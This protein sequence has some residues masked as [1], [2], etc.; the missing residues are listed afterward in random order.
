[1]PYGNDMVAALVDPVIS[2]RDVEVEV[3]GVA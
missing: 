3:D 2:V 1:M